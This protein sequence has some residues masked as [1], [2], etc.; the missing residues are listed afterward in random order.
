MDLAGVNHLLRRWAGKPTHGICAAMVHPCAWLHTFEWSSIGDNTEYTRYP[1]YVVGYKERESRRTN[2]SSTLV[3][4]NRTSLQKNEPTYNFVVPH[5]KILRDPVS[6]LAI[7]L[8][9]TLDQA[10]LP[11]KQPDW[12]WS[13]ASSWCSVCPS[14][15]QIVVVDTWHRLMFYSGAKLVNQ[16]PPMPLGKC[17]ANPSIPQPS[18]A[19]RSPI[20]RDNISQRSWKTW[21]EYNSDKFLTFSYS[22]KHFL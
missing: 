10:D 20:S 17:I 5:R 15:Y 7:L 14:T 18:R 6:A 3:F 11:S 21:G 22:H 12:N 2:F 19:Q 1:G 8:H 13:D 16:A 4:S 9:F